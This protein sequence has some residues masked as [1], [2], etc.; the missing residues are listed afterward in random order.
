MRAE[1]FKKVIQRRIYVEEISRGEWQDG[2]EECWKKEIELLTED[3][4][5]AMEFLQ[6]ECTPDEYSWISEVIDDIALKTK[7]REF[8]ECYKSLMTK[9]ADECEQYNIAGSI[10]FAEAALETE[11]T[12]SEE[13]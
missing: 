9:F 8:V 2:I 11:D 12:D 13:S 4:P 6:T 3:I 1:E 10:K 7:N 5:S